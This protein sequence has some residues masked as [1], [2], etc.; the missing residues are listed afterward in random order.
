[1]ENTVVIENLGRLATQCELQAVRLSP[2]RAERIYLE[3]LA[4]RYREAQYDEMQE[5]R[6]TA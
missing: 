1:M 5:E 2:Y 6:K 4:D 3:D